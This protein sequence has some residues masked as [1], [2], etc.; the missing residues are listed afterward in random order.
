MRTRV[1]IGEFARLSHLS[2]KALRH[3]HEIGLLV[4][5]ETTGSGYR[6]YD[7]TQ[8]G[9]A[10]VIRRL[11]ALEMPLPDITT[12]LRSPDAASRD[13]AVA[14][15]LRRMEDALEQTRAVVGSLRELLERPIRPYEVSIRRQHAVRAIVRRDIVAS[16]E[17]EAWSV[18]TFAELGAALGAA[19]RP[20]AGPMGSLFTSAFFEDG[21]G[22]VTAF[23]PI[24]LTGDV[25]APVTR[26][27][28]GVEMLPAAHYA[29]TV[30]AGPYHDLDR[31]YGELGSYVAENLTASN[32]PIREHYVVGPADVGD[33]GALRT[34]L[35]WPLD[36][37]DGG[38]SGRDP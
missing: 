33:P 19:G 25:P 12:V 20:I 6:R 16:A 1:N 36:V 11:R 14:G 8:V 18:A 21:V 15:H 2:V 32:A 29:V 35:L 30:H 9:D 13:A 24:D 37:D 26:A 28:L 22:E 4:P 17:I 7:V 10:H 23:A 5:A 31:T 3:Y 27:A 38:S 34:E